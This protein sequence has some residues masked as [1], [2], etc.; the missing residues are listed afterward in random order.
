MVKVVLNWIGKFAVRNGRYGATNYVNIIILCR[1]TQPC[2]KG[3]CPW[4]AMDVSGFCKNWTLFE[5]KSVKIMQHWPPRMDVGVSP[6]DS[7]CE[8]IPCSSIEILFHIVIPIPKLQWVPRRKLHYIRYSN[9]QVILCDMCMRA[10]CHN[11]VVLKI[12][13]VFRLFYIRLLNGPGSSVSVNIAYIILL[14]KSA[15]SVFFIC[16]PNP[17]CNSVISFQ[18]HTCTKCSVW[19]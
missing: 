8:Y 5:R 3:T 19:W 9:L 1:Y 14:E 16:A 7:L 11:S 6:I 18:R 17:Y 4:W 13:D 10:Q 2:L 15:T 12:S